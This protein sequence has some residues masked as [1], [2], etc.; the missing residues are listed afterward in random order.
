MQC[1]NKGCRQHLTEQAL[2]IKAGIIRYYLCDQCTGIWLDQGGG[3]LQAGYDRTRKS[4][5]SDYPCPRCKNI[6]L[7]SVGH[8]EK[9]DIK[10]YQCRKCSGLRIEYWNKTDWQDADGDSPLLDFLSNLGLVYKHEQ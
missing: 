2:Q 6:F 8:L 4:Q 7:E 10:S 5:I 9:F 1:S 3:Q